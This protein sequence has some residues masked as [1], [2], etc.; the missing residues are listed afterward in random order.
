LLRG[1][2]FLLLIRSG[3]LPASAAEQNAVAI[4]GYDTVAY[5]KAGKA[6]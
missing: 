1:D 2:S 3:D 5:F 6:I 4:K